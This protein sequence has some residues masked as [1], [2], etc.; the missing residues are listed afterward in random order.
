MQAKEM[1]LLRLKEQAHARV[2]EADLGDLEREGEF[3]DLT[4]T[5]G[6][7]REDA[8]KFL[9]QEQVENLYGREN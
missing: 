7:D 4:I 5:V 2:N 9:S 6:I 3:I 8:G 1:V